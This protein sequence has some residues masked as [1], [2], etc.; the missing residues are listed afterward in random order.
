MSLVFGDM[1]T[2]KFLLSRA[3]NGCCLWLLVSSADSLSD[4]SRSLRA[5]SSLRNFSADNL[6]IS[7][8]FCESRQISVFFNGGVVQT[9]LI[10]FVL[11]GK[12]N[13][14]LSFDFLG[15]RQY[16]LQLFL[17]IVP[18]CL[19]DCC[20]IRVRSDLFQEESEKHKNMRP[21]NEEFSQHYLHYKFHVNYEGALQVSLLAVAVCHPHHFQPGSEISAQK[22]KRLR[23]G[24]E[25]E[26]NQITSWPGWWHQF[27]CCR[28]AASSTWCAAPVPWQGWKSC[29]RD[30]SPSPKFWN[31]FNEFHIIH[32]QNESRLSPETPMWGTKHT[33]LG[34]NSK[35]S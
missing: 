15:N 25:T 32:L 7:D 21:K 14:Q 13:R 28:R 12:P 27:Q 23:K 6:L 34:L 19:T 17:V 31:A 30:I 5:A 24:R 9:N 8:S 10:L 26:A 35:I 22:Q 16:V 3:A 20:Q 1:G 2:I 29:E 4:N 18:V 33:P 11:L